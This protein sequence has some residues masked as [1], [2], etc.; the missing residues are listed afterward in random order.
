MESFLSVLTD[1][2]AKEIIKSDEQ[3]RVAHEVINCRS[4]GKAN[5]EETIQRLKELEDEVAKLKVRCC[6]ALTHSLSKLGVLVDVCC[7]SAHCILH[8]AY[9]CAAL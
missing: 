6:F 3:Q 2:K 4:E 7:P 5:H 8:D 1:M 9:L